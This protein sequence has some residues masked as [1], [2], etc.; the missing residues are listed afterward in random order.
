MNP[1][2]VKFLG[3]FALLLAVITG[4]AVWHIT[5]V[6]KAVNTET[7][8]VTALWNEDRARTRDAALAETAKNTAETERRLAT[9]KE[10]ADAAQN[11]A[12]AAL[13]AASR[14]A[15]AVAI[16]RH[17]IA[18]TA[19]RSGDVPSDPSVAKFCPGSAALG[20]VLATCAAEY[21]AMGLDAEDDRSRGLES[22]ADY[23]ALRN[24]PAR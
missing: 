17:T 8:R 12:K 14:S 4:V 6:H 3:G 20:N 9:Q 13:D 23:D 24:N 21:R 7:L 2:V 15:D 5:A 16:L 22:N 18:A 1:L 19:P 11:R 10:A